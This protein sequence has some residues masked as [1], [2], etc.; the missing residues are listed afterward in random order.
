ML[1][2]RMWN[3]L[4]GCSTLSAG[5]VGNTQFMDADARMVGILKRT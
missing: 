4:L 1:Q 3:F 5:R 2:Q